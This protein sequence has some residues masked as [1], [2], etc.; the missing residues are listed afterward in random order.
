[1]TLAE[2]SSG[3]RSREYFAAERACGDE[4]RAGFL[5]APLKALGDVHLWFSVPTPVGTAL[6]THRLGWVSCLRLSPW[7]DRA[8]DAEAFVD[9]VRHEIGAEAMPD[10]DVD[11]R[12]VA[13]VA[14]ALES[15]R[16]DVPVDLS[17]RSSFHRQVLRAAARIPRGEVRTYAELAAAVGRPRAARAVGTA[18]ARNPVAL[19]IPCHR[20]VPSGGGVG[21]YGYGADVKAELLRLEGA[22]LTPSRS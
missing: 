7:A 10:P 3:L 22:E 11:T 6:V 17:S 13:R 4:A 8:L 12:L 21:S 16:T 2:T 19:L 9:H 15:G 1:M 14:D 5:E 18:M 20:V